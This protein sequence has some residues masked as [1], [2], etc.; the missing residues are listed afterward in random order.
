MKEKKV[1]IL[2]KENIKKEMGRPKVLRNVNKAKGLN[3]AL[4]FFSKFWKK[5]NKE[6]DND[7]CYNLMEMAINSLEVKYKKASKARKVDFQEQIKAIKGF[8][9]LEFPRRE[10]NIEMEKHCDSNV[11]TVLIH[12]PKNI[13]PM[14]KKVLEAL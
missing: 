13:L 3:L 11:P 2:V 10:I 14:D 9:P 4:S 12:N 7:T 6:P 5:F 1:F 8:I